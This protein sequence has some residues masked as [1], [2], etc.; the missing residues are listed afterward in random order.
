[1]NYKDFKATVWQ[2]KNTPQAA[3]RTAPS[4]ARQR[5]EAT[6]AANKAKLDAQLAPV[7]KPA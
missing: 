7:T 5:I 3:A 6:Q 1:M 4:E 2:S